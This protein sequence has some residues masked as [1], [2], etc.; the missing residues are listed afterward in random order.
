MIHKK[1]YIALSADS[2]HHAHINLIKKGLNYGQ[3]TIGL[4]T[5]KAIASRKR[6]P[7]LSYNERKII[8]ENIKGVTKV[9]PQNE[10]DYSKNILKLK[11][12][13]MIHGDD[14]TKGPE[15]NLRNRAIKALKK[16]GGKLIEIPYTTG[17]SS[18][19]LAEAQ[20]KL[21]ITSDLRIK[22]LRRCLSSKPLSIFI[23]THSPIS[24]IIAEKVN[25]KT[26]TGLK[27]YDGFWSS[28]LTDST[29]LGMPDNEVLNLSER[30]EN[31][32][33][34]F[35]V[36]TKPLIMDID[37]GGQLEHLKINAKSIERTGVSAIIME[38]KTG[39]KKNSLFGT[40]VQQTQEKIKKFCDKIET[41][42][43]NQVSEDFMVIA[44]IE[45]LIL[46]KGMDDALKRA[47]SYVSH[48]AD[49]IM[50]HSKESKPKEVFEFSKKFRKI[51]KNVPLICVP[52]SYNS[53]KEIELIKNNFNLVIYANHLFRAS[54]PA[55]LKT[56]EKILK[57]GR[58]KEIDK[59]LIS[60]KKILE[61]IP[62]TK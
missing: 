52:T 49:G 54:Y 18:T 24:A 17:I 35:E 53:V 4:L 48:G 6:I 12:D 7:L 23:E 16:V 34:I 15:L 19:A 20:I 8:L 36:T 62:G 26:K 25:V 32:S 60:I 61:L 43:V 29:K 46:Q 51:F 38:D 11:P 47:K 33:K 9:I 10:W 40:S 5:D 37:T 22:S 2:L 55:M 42:K 57:F 14:W 31:I 45:S 13:F 50:I 1:V 58:T 39:L 21:G 28:S 30:L 3:I 59:S 41:I 44:R 56:A 27:Q